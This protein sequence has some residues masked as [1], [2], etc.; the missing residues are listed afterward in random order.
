MNIEQLLT[1][2]VSRQQIVSAVEFVKS[3]TY[4]ENKVMKVV[5]YWQFKYAGNNE[6]DPGHTY[7]LKLD[8]LLSLEVP[9]AEF[10]TSINVPSKY[11]DLLIPA[12]TT[13]TLRS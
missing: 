3:K 9:D 11:K 2:I 6:L 7:W 5:M 13:V 10:K 12:Q 8:E 1:D 4:V